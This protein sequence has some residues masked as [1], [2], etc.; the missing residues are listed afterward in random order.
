MESP[1]VS[2][3]SITSFHGS[4]RLSGP[5]PPN[6]KAPAFAKAA[7]DGPVCGVGESGA[8]PVCGL[9]G[10]FASATGQLL[11]LGLKAPRKYRRTVLRST[12][13][14][15]AIRRL[16]QPC[17]CRATIICCCVTLS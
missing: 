14:S 6:A 8:E 16:D 13:N 9:A 5:A 10:E 2:A 4:H 11:T 3:A 15:R 7:A 17:S 12:P 1:D